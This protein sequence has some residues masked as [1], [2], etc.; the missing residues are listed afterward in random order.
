MDYRIVASAPRS[1]LDDGL[2]M[3]GMLREPARRSG[4]MLALYGSV[5]G[6]NQSGVDVDMFAVPWRHVSLEEAQNV[7]KR[8]A[9]GRI[10]FFLSVR[11][12]VA[13]QILFLCELIQQGNQP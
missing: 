4:F 8:S 5:T 13:A 7:V 6:S 2:L 9:F 11:A 3:M 12:I 10:F 1:T